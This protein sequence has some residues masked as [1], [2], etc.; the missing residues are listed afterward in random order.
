M[1]LHKIKGFNTAEGN[2]YQSEETV[3]RIRENLCQLSIPSGKINIEYVRTQDSYGEKNKPTNK[4][5][6]ELNIELS[7]EVQKANKY[8]GEMLNIFSNPG[9]A[10]PTCTEIQ[11]HPDRNGYHQEKTS[12]W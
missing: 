8:K 6:N 12:K 7:K 9:D 11:P 5:A 4:W 3:Y 1:K 2:N 10:N